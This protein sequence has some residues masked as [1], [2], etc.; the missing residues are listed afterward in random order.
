VSHQA[1]GSLRLQDTHFN[2]DVALSQIKLISQYIVHTYKLIK[3]KDLDLILKDTVNER[4]FTLRRKILMLVYSCIV[5]EWFSM[6]AADEIK[7]SL[8]SL[9]Q[10]AQGSTH[11][12]CP[13]GFSSTL[14][15]VR[16]HIKVYHIKVETYKRE[17]AL[18]IKQ[19]PQVF[20]PKRDYLNEEF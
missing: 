8:F 18:Q 14:Q 2:A 11:C 4:M 6:C 19:N 15:A 17:S 3:R 20:L 16:G 5:F 10:S 13:C 12:H 7:V 9:I 1:N